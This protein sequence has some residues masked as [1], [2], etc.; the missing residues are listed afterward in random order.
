VCGAEDSGRFV[1]IFGGYLRL[2]G[3]VGEWLSETNAG[4]GLDRCAA[5]GRWYRGFGCALRVVLI[6]PLNYTVFACPQLVNF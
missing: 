2:A 5:V 3:S 6:A 4:S 1:S